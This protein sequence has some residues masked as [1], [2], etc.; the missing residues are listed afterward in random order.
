MKRIVKIKERELISSIE[1][2]LS[3]QIT[4]LHMI[5]EQVIL[6]KG[7][8]PYEYKKDGDKYYTRKK[9][10]TTWI[11][12]KDKVADAIANKVFK[13]S[14]SSTQLKSST[15]KVSTPSFEPVSRPDINVG[16]DTT[17]K[18]GKGSTNTTFS[19]YILG[20]LEKATKLIGE[21]SLRSYE[22][23]NKIIESEGMGSDSFIIVNK[24]ASIASLF[25]P[26]YEF[27]TKSPITTGYFKDTES[28]DD[29]L[30]YRKWFD[31]TMDYISQN[32]NSSD[33]KKAK[34]YADSINVRVNNLDYDKHLKG[35]KGVKFYSYNA[36]K[37]TGYARTPS[38]VYKL[39]TPGS[40]KGYSGTG[41]NLFPLVD[42]ETGEKLAQG[43]HGAAGKGRESI[44]QRA[45]SEDTNISKDYTRA[46]SGCVNVTGD[47]IS[48]MQEYNPQYV[49]ILPDSGS[50]VDVP[51]IVSMKSWSD[52]IIE[53]GSNCVRS[54]INLFM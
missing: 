1:N 19:D 46:G 35:K 48:A 47:F 44:L 15:P 12:T 5:S 23:L 42:I 6:G 51:K 43:V 8:D 27:I 7:N 50:S 3:E 37:E 18:I 41:P 52:K 31:I 11:L 49:I 45:G 40:V 9:G 25:G 29:T 34:N 14:P 2:L 26:G 21:I 17:A 38:G 39:G 36:L 16:S 24:D 10:G 22:Q 53:L 33:A 20:E 32:P 28:K 13:V 54:L 4:S 30:T